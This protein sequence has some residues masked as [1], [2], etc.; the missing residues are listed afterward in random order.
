[1]LIINFSILVKM[2][3][4]QVCYISGYSFE[5]FKQVR[6]E[7][8]VIFCTAYNQFALEA[9]KNNGIDYVLKPFTNIHIKDSVERY[10]KL[11]LN[12]AASSIDY[13]GILKM[14]QSISYNEKKPSSILVNYKEKI[15]P[16]KISE[17]AVFNVHHKMTQLTI[18]NNQKFFI[19]N[20]LDALEDVCGTAFYRAN[21]Q[22]LINR[23]TVQEALHFYSRKL[24]INLKIEGEHEIIISKNK[25]PEFLTWLRQ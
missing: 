16:V 3:A 14:L 9:F 8:P 2:P 5:I 13:T 18:F 11:R 25:V 22:Y 10:K 6:L 17:I 24:V 20:T 21:R 19:S 15:I 1:M 12:F 7:V 23:A 4:K